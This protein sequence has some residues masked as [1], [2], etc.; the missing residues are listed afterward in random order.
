MMKLLPVPVED[1]DIEEMFNFAD[2]DSRGEISY[3]EFQVQINLAFHC[4]CYQFSMKV[5][6][7][8]QQPPQQQK[9]H[10]SDFELNL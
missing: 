9:P 1:D 5:M 3:E 8:P 7:K 10:I 6:I 4:R 2:K